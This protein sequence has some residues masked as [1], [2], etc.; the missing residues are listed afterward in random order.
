[1]S[2]PCSLT[3]LTHRAVCPASKGC[4]GRHTNNAPWQPNCAPH[5]AHNKQLLL[6]RTLTTVQKRRATSMPAPPSTLNKT[7]LTNTTPPV[8]QPQMPGMQPTK[9]GQ[10]IQRNS[11]SIPHQCTQN[12]TYMTQLRTD[13][14]TRLAISHATIHRCQ[15]T[16]MCQQGTAITWTESVQH[17]V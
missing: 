5:S 6:M 4:T 11:F 9:L 13:C 1:M 10:A 16:S 2:T 14:R 15:A 12:E 3:Q 17:R 8:T 7:Q